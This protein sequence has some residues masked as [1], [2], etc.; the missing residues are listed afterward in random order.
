LTACWFA[1]AAILYA[2]GLWWGLPNGLMHGLP[3]GADELGPVGAVNEVY[4]VFFARH[5]TFNPQYP[6]LQ[7][8]CQVTFVAPYYLFLWLTGHISQPAPNYPFG[9]DDPGRQLNVMTVA[10]R[11]PSLLMA[12]GVVALAFRTGERLRNRLTGKIFAGFVLLIYP[13]FYYARTSNVD[14]GALFWTALALL[15]YAHLLAGSTAARSWYLFA[16]A[17]ALA[18]AT[19]DASY[20]ACLPAGVVAVVLRLRAS[21]GQGAPLSQSLRVPAVA[22]AM[23]GVVYAVAS[24]LLLRPARF[25]SHVDFI[26]HGSPGG[27]FYNRYPATLGGY[28]SVGQEFSNRV[29]D[30]MSAPMLAIALAGLAAW[31]LRDR[32]QLLWLV[33]V[34]G[35]LVGV[36][37]PVRFVLL[38]FVLIVAYVLALPA[39]DILATALGSPRRWLRTAAA[40]SAAAV[41][42]WGAVRAGDLTFQMLYDSRYA[43]AEWLTRAAHAGDRVGHFIPA[44]NLPRLP[45]GVR[46]VQMWNVEPGTVVRQPEFILSIPLEDFERVHEWRLPDDFFARL[47]DGSAG[48]REATVIQGRSLFHDRPA[49]HVYPPVRIFVRNDV[50]NSRPDARR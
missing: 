46:T 29:L 42:V 31:A 43:A 34:L 19:K 13:L 8:F 18:T 45:A 16:I 15:G 21:R 47:S 22:L 11:L 27:L 38:R 24:G 9:L 28:L 33:P 1:A 48:Y 40:A 49:T 26:T 4:G 12:A 23:S 30:A 17:S 2:P 3:W 39:A 41:I 35:V 7:Y 5:P 10:A 14:A 36:I 44:P 32:K 37:A 25:A 20:A 6:L 50:W